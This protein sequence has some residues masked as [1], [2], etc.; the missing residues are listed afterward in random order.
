MQVERQPSDDQPGS[1]QA[2][3]NPELSQRLRKLAK[4]SQD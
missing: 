2:P 3:Q 1:S 4:A